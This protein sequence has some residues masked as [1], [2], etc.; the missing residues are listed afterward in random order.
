VAGRIE[1]K[2]DELKDVFKTG[3]QFSINIDSREI[4]FTITENKK[5]DENLI[6]STRNA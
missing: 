2:L 6:E 1:N 3:G 5:E 4:A